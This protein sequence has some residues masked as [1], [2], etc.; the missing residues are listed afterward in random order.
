MANR[1]R[2]VTQQVTTLKSF[3]KTDTAVEKLDHGLAHLEKHYPGEIPDDYSRFADPSAGPALPST[4]ALGRI[5][6][7]YSEIDEAGYFATNDAMRKAFNANVMENAW[8]MV[9]QLSPSAIG[10][11]LRN[12]KEAFTSRLDMRV[13]DNGAYVLK[14]NRAT[15]AIRE[16][17]A[18]QSCLVLAP[19]ALSDNGVELESVTFYATLSDSKTLVAYETGRDLH[20]EMRCT[21][22]YQK[23]KTIGK[24]FLMRSCDPQAAARNCRMSYESSTDTLT[25]PIGRT[26]DCIVATT[27]AP[28]KRMHI[29]I[30]TLDGRVLQMVPKTEPDARTYLTKAAREHRD[31]ILALKDMSARM[32]VPYDP[33]A[34]KEPVRGFHEMETYHPRDY[35]P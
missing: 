18:H 8:D 16:F 25:I 11:E 7:P 32:G 4:Y 17:R 14:R 13:H 15:G 29:D 24:A 19:D 27:T 26:G 6:E 35:I 30:H 2:E 22:A 12:A 9:D 10:Y 5:A 1:A 20:D 28:D 33:P 31:E 23:A 34:Q 21:R 3:A